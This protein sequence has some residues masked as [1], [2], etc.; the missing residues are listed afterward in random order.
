MKTR[1]AGDKLLLGKKTGTLGYRGETF[2]KY[3]LCSVWKGKK[4]NHV[5]VFT[6]Q[7]KKQNPLL[8]KISIVSMDFHRRKK[9]LHLGS[10]ALHGMAMST[11]PA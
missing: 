2:F 10:N 8:K 9:I 5:H 3:I 7:R 4:I 6:T 11:S 1:R